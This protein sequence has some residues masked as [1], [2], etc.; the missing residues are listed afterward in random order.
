[1]T[2]IKFDD[3]ERNIRLNRYIET[4]EL[5]KEFNEWDDKLSGLLGYHGLKQ[6]D[7]FKLKIINNE[8]ITLDRPSIFQPLSRWYDCQSCRRTAIFIEDNLNAY[9][10]FLS[11]VSCF[12]TYKSLSIA[13][14]CFY[15]KITFYTNGLYKALSSCR[16]LFNEQKD[17]DKKILELQGQLNSWMNDYGYK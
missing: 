16:S 12:K 15:E 14:Q 7:G 2:V 9:L 10:S 4:M 6:R 3:N 17:Y 8:R 1:M 13:E 5:Q 11:K